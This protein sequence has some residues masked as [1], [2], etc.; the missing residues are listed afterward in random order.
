MALQR[1]LGMFG[2]SPFEDAFAVASNRPPKIKTVEND[3]WDRGSQGFRDLND[4]SWGSASTVC[5]GPLDLN[6][7][8]WGSASTACAAAEDV[9]FDTALCSGQDSPFDME[10]DDSSPR[11]T[12]LKNRFSLCRMNSRERPA[13]PSKR[14]RFSVDSLSATRHDA[15]ESHL[16]ENSPS[17]PCDSVALDMGLSEHQQFAL[18]AITGTCDAMPCEAF[19]PQWGGFRLRA[20]SDSEDEAAPSRKFRGRVEDDYDLEQATADYA[21]E[22]PL[23]STSQ[24]QWRAIVEAK[25]KLKRSQARKLLYASGN[26]YVVLEVRLHYARVRD[27]LLEEA[28]E[29]SAELSLL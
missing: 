16:G 10:N 11:M 13:P 20:D 21:A 9:C 3:C 15:E 19:S 28:Q 1:S 27:E 6:D 12:S 22:F 14:V 8:S 24:Q 23:G 26:E 17:V 29:L 7:L 25:I 18:D 5:A 4:L 2:A